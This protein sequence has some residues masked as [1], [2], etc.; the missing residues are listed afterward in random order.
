MPVFTVEIPDVAATIHRQVI[1]SVVFNVLRQLGYDQADVIYNG[2]YLTTAQPGSTIGEKRE[3]SYG[4][5]DKVVV[6]IDEQRDDEA[7]NDRGMGF[8]YQPPFFHNEFFGIILAPD[9]A[10]YNV[11]VTISRRAASRA[12]ISSWANEL[13]RK[14][15]LGRD[16]IETQASYHYRIPPTL[17][18]LLGDLHKAMTAKLSD[19]FDL[20]DLLVNGFS[21]AVTVISNQSGQYQEYAVRNTLTRILSVF[22]PSAEMEQEKDK[23]SGAWTGRF[24]FRFTYERPEAVTAYYPAILNNTLLAPEWWQERVMPGIGDMRGAIRNVYIDA[25]DSLRETIPFINLPV[26][27]P[28]CDVP[29]L[30]HMGRDP[31]ELDLVLGYLELEPTEL[32]PLVP[33]FNLT[34]L[35]NIQLSPALL[36]YLKEAYEDT[37]DG[38]NSIIR[39]MVY[40]DNHQLDPAVILVDSALNV[41]GNFQ[42]KIECTYRFAITTRLN[43]CWLP[44]EAVEIIRRHPIFI[45]DWLKDFH[46]GLLP[47]LT[48]IYDTAQAAINS[49]TTNPGGLDANG[50]PIPGWGTEDK[51]DGWSNTGG[52]AGQYPIEYPDLDSLVDLLSPLP[53]PSALAYYTDAET[54]TDPLTILNGRLIAHRSE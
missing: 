10:R 51:G 18:N 47:G 48:P 43:W 11:D 46:P 35:G 21:K 6:E 30:P 50:N 45:W 33:F 4:A 20:L 14:F 3:L 15:A 34:Q 44:N 53:D 19:K 40:E 9:N 54:L 24:Q 16:V 17:L 36:A 28:N 23:D 29:S 26:Y 41:V 52:G 1:D 39:V 8:E 7:L 5:T 38:S 31:R 12:V 27:L 13:R 37:P 2:A 42:A 22:D 25:Q 32:Q 49:G